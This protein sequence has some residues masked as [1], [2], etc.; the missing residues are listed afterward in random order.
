MQ[1]AEEEIEENFAEISIKGSHPREVESVPTEDTLVCENEDAHIR[2]LVND[3]IDAAFN[4][5][6]R[7]IHNDDHVYKH[8]KA[9]KQKPSSFTV[10]DNWI[11]FRFVK[12]HANLEDSGLSS[13]SALSKG[14]FSSSAYSAVGRLFNITGIN[15]RT[16]GQVPF[17]EL[18][19]P[20]PEQVSEGC[21]LRQFTT[22]AAVCVAPGRGLL[23]VGC[24]PADDKP[25]ARLYAA[26]NDDG[27]AEHGFYAGP[28]AAV[29]AGTHIIEKRKKIRPPPRQTVSFGAGLGPRQGSPAADGRTRRGSASPD[30]SMRRAS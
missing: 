19:L 4:T 9:A 5:I 12:L 25:E 16:D 17:H 27:R 30:R 28:P 14:S 23:F 21:P 26:L 10:P 7:R 6:N 18:P 13:T 1:V 3:L 29:T 2:E 20:A 8:N 11:W 24:S 15:F 22:F